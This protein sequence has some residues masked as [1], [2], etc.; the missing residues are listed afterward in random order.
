V[1]QKLRNV[2]S[3]NFPCADT[4]TEG[5]VVEITGD[6]TIAVPS[7]AGSLNIVGTVARKRGYLLSNANNAW[8]TPEGGVT[9]GAPAECTVE[10]RFREHRDDRVSGAAVPVGPFVFDAT[11]KVIPYAAGTHDPSAIRGLV[12]V[13]AAASGATVETLEY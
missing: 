3:L 10:T 12:I 5:N 13:H 4:I 1:K 7:A 2:L 9:G 11:G 6:Y 8:P